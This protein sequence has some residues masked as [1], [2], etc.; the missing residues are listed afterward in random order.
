MDYPIDEVTIKLPF[1]NKLSWKIP[2]TLWSICCHAPLSGRYIFK[3]QD[4]SYV[5][6]N[7]ATATL[8]WYKKFFN[9]DPLG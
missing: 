6:D 4:I 2:L 1:A 7:D 8:Y 9:E 5:D 3:S